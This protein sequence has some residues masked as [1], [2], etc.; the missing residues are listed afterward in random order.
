M[1]KERES[2]IELLRII[3]ILMV[4]GVHAFLYGNYFETA[5]NCG[6]I[7]SS[8]AWLL[9]LMFRP[10]VNIF[11]IITGYFMSREP[12]NLKRSYKRVIHIYASV[13]FYSVVL[14][15][16]TLLAG[17]DFYTVDGVTTPVHIIVMKMFFPVLSQNWYYVSDYIFLCMFAPFV[18]VVLQNITRRQYQVLIVV[19][20]L[21]MSLWYVLEDIVILEDVIRTYGYDGISDGK[22]VFSFI[23]IYI[24]GGYI[25]MYVKKNEHVRVRY[26]MVVILCLLLNY[27]LATRFDDILGMEDI[28]ISYSNPLI[29]LMAV[30][31]LI[32]FKDMHFHN[33]FINVLASAT[34]GVYAIHEFKYVR[35]AI[36]SVFDFGKMDCSHLLKNLIS[37]AGVILIIF[38]L[39]TGIELLRKRLFRFISHIKI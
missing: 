7:V 17:P 15:L 12:L 22:N 16:I 35:Y 21:V 4:I 2:G 9:R 26:L 3:A 13:Y 37:I 39:C 24:L 27:V 29:I 10:A 14:S 38:L 1:E 5:R 36:W 31:M 33:H 18:N 20:S 23:Y 30:F 34:L 8:S 32:F 28:I 25:R 19:S 11:I 6:G